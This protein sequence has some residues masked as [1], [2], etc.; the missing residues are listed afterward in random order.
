MKNLK[1]KLLLLLSLLLLCVSVFG[2]SAMAEET[3]P[4]EAS[5]VLTYEGMLARTKDAS[6]I[7][8]LFRIDKAALAA[9]TG[10]GYRVE[11][12]AVMGV[13]SLDGTAYNTVSD[14][15]VIANGSAGYVA[16]AERATAIV[17]YSSA[18]ASYA[19]N[20]FLT[21]DDA[22]YT[23]AYTTIFSEKFENATYY[24]AEFC[25]RGFVVLT[26]NGVTTIL[27]TD[28]IG[29]VLGDEVSLVEL[30]SYFVTGGYTGDKAEEY[31]ALPKFHETV[32][33]VGFNFDADALSGTYEATSVK[34]ASD[35]TAYRQ[36]KKGEYAGGAVTLTTPTYTRPGIYEVEFTYV[37]NGVAVSSFAFRNNSANKN[38]TDYT[39]TA[40][41][42]TATF[43]SVAAG[44]TTTDAVDPT[45]ASLQKVKLT[46]ILVSGANSITGYRRAAARK[47]P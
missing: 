47:A 19:S 26:K 24:E 23:F 21:S 12:G 30:I 43:F 2:V 18:G 46:A 31:A 14:L 28:G 45:A 25:Y 32:S 35:G 29:D 6:G 40:S 1:A 10:Q 4:D 36:L 8:S 41:A 11:I 20:R 33:K 39:S 42:G 15:S 38:N 22:A 37:T 44:A 5:S 13:A 3:L 17:V 16:T 27:Y 34:T 9:L 7:R